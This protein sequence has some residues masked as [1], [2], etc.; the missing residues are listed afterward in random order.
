M[1]DFNSYYNLVLQF[2]SSHLLFA[3]ALGIIILYALYKKPEGTIKFLAFCLFLV[4][5]FYTMSLLSQSGSSGVGQ[6]DTLIHKSERELQ[7]SSR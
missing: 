4:A 3:V 7:D 5:V 1:I 6:Q 2:L